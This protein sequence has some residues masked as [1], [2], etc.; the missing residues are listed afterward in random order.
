MSLVLQEPLRAAFYAP[1]YAALAL[2]AYRAEGVDVAFSPAASNPDE[3]SHRIRSGE[4]DVIWGGPMRVLAAR[5]E[6]SSCDLV[7]FSEVVARDPFLLI[8]STPNAA[9]RFDDLFGARIAMFSPVAT[10]WL[11]LQEDMRR[12]GLASRH[13]RLVSIPPEGISEALASGT[14]DVAQV[15]EPMAQKLIESGVAH[16]WHAA[17]SRGPVSYSSFYAKRATVAAKRREFAGLARGI[18]RTQLWLHENSDAAVAAVIAPWFDAPV[19]RLVAVVRR[20]RSL[21]VWAVGPGFD[22]AGYEWLCSALVGGGMIRGRVA[23]EDVVYAGFADE[24]LA[25]PLRPLSSALL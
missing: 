9:F 3:S 13:L 16:L 21:G 2:G 23:Y 17:A 25:N 24:I 6:D 22:R 12:A 14:A 1:F 15:P 20:Y 18:H 10:P 5:E 19:S 4:V 8:G 7:C 11:C